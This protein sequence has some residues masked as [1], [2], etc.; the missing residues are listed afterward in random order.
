MLT[1]GFPRFQGDLFGT[2]VFELARELTAGGTKVEVL[3]PH[4]AGLQR[5][6][7][8]DQVEVRRFR[9]FWPAALQAV[10]YGGGIPTN[11]RTRWAARLQV[12]FFLLGFCWGAL[13]RA[14]RSD[15]VHCHWT[16]SGLVA[17]LATRLRR[18]PL[19]LSVR[20]SD[21]HLV[22]RGLMARLH[23]QIYAWMDIV[24][25]VSE[26][27]AHKLE[28]MGVPR[29]KIRVVANGVDQRFRPGDRRQARLRLALPPED[30]IVLFVGMLVPIKGLDVLIEALAK[31]E[32]AKPVVLLVGDGPLRSDLE[33]QAADRGLV[34]HLRL[35]GRQSSEEIPIWMAA[36]DVLVLPSRS[37]GRPNVVLEAQACGLPVVAT[38]VGGTPELV[39]DGKTGLLVESDDAQAL[40]Q[41]IERL[42]QDGELRDRLR[43]AGREQA[44]GMT[45]AASADQMVAIYCGLLEA[46]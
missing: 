5:R 6:E 22:E 10:A 8:F 43:G 26:D 11:I 9:Y 13:R 21:I 1:T 35:V 44:A 15:I 31:I 18:R 33:R 39:R 12:P 28:G 3:A 45:W 14:W 34:D 46:A 42:R 38:A 17:Y 23:R 27:I 20:G 40:A 7:R 25:A 16:I 30:F 24:V 36:A 4:E 32:G 37:E 19:V 2:F 41:A 29:E